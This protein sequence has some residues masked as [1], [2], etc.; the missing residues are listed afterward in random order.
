MHQSGRAGGK[1]VASAVGGSK[2]CERPAGVGRVGGSGEF[3]VHV[4]ESVC[5]WGGG[6]GGR[7][8]GGALK[9]AIAC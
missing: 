7:S 9:W 8:A 1:V 3:G 4:N 2:V 6:G 5:V